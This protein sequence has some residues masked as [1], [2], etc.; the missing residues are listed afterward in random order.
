MVAR[1]EILIHNTTYDA[2]G[3]V[4]YHYGQ[5]PPATLDYAQ[6]IGPL[7]DTVADLA[8]FDAMLRQLQNS[9]LLLAPLRA[10]DAVISS[11]MEGT[12][13]TVEEVLR[14]E[15]DADQDGHSPG[16]RNDTLEVALYAR[17]L[18]MVERQI[19]DGHD[20]SESLIRT[21]HRILLAAGRGADKRPGDYKAQQNYIG[22]K[23]RRRIDF[24]PASPEALGPAMDALVAYM[25]N[26]RVQ[27]VLR[28]AIAHAEFEALHPF[29]DGNGRIGRM[30]IPLL[31]WRGGALSAPHFFVSDYFETNKPEYIARLRAVSQSGDWTG[32][33]MFFLGALRAQARDNIAVVGR[34][35]NL[36][37]TTRTRLRDL[38]R[39]R[40][41][42]EAL[43]Y[44]F[45]HP[46]FRNNRFTREAGIPKPT[47]NNFTR[48]MVEHGILRTVIP[49]A[50]RAPGLYA[51]G[52]L[53]EIL[54]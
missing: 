54:S 23:A 20:I 19:A 11:R 42:V 13:S 16:A 36:Y 52:E 41:T 32:W 10:R 29:E 46:V 28:T 43:N 15:A 45:A 26:G 22:E 8:R 5:F 30:L 31:L 27:P 7:A 51:F 50:G 14:L 37:Q 35:D 4:H 6:L 33:C 39:S 3:A 18:R 12:I 34:I 47:A 38:L 25:R 9:E 2:S 24:V 40:S 17:A 48:T 53:L 1:T 21:A 49:P 44:M